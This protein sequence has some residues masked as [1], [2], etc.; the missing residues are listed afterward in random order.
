M[1]TTGVL[2]TDG[3]VTTGTIDLAGDDDWFAIDL[4][5]GQAY[6]IVLSSDTIFAF[7][8][9]LNLRDSSGGFVTSG[10]SFDGI[11]DTLDFTASETG[12][13]YV[14]V[15]GDE[16]IGVTGDYELTANII[17]DDFSADV[18]T[19]GVL[20]AD[21][22]VTTGTIDFVNDIDWFALEMI[23]IKIVH[24]RLFSD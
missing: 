14:D 24:N 20:T 10:T 21:G 16:F 3:S 12:T 4:V 9:L 11:N 13:F 15:Q 19:T 2:E 7:D 1:N 18:N 17:E 5:V 23:F 22:T 8:L 6:S